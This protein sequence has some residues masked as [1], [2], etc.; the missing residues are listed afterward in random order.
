MK[1]LQNWKEHHKKTVAVFEG[2]AIAVFFLAVISQFA[3]LSHI[4]IALPKMAEVLPA[5]LVMLTN[6]ERASQSLSTLQTNDLLTVA[7]QAKANDMATRGYFSHVSPEGLTPWFW[8]DGVGYPYEKAGENLAVNFVDS[9]DVMNGWLNSPT[10]KANIVSEKYKEIGIATAQGQ[11]KGKQAIFIVQYFGTQ[12]PSVVPTVVVPNVPAPATASVPPPAMVQTSP[13]LE[14]ETENIEDA[15]L[16]TEDVILAI[17]ETTRNEV[18]GIEFEAA[19]ID[20]VAAQSSENVSAIERALSAPRTIV[21]FVLLALLFVVA[22]KLAFAIHL[23]HPRLIAT[24]FTLLVL[25]A[26]L[27]YIN[28]SSLFLGDIL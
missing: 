3:F 24:L 26:I 11:Y 22:L 9:V 27:L 7:A 2:L 10:H 23:R 5:V 8:L 1:F 19:L 4:K 18:L 28:N 25:I 15:I 20:S 14:L 17:E 6:D 21:T 13:E 12:K 16:V